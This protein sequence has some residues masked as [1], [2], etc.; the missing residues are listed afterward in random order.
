MPRLLC[1]KEMKMYVGQAR[2]KELIDILKALGWGEMTQPK[3][4][5]PR[6]R[7]FALDNYAYSCFKN[8]KPWSAEDFKRGI[9]ECE[10][11]KLVP[12]FVVAPDIV[13]GGWK[14]LEFSLSWVEQLRGFAPI[15]LAVQDGMTV[16]G[17]SPHLHLFD[18]IF[19]GG[20]VPW[21]LAS[22]YWWTALAHGRGMPCHVGRISGRTNVQ[23]VKSWGAD[24]I[25][26]CVPLWSADNRNAVVQGLA[27]LPVD[28]DP[29]YLEQFLTG[30][31]AL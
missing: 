15:Y 29:P 19:V 18:G 26:S 3:E 30:W 27:D 13:A 2:G 9:G 10:K 25:D 12:D 24:S 6:R 7:P 5:P 8:N 17:V 23:L 20:Q 4:V 1:G 31:E 14:S 22:G 28:F 21:K 11:R 16:D